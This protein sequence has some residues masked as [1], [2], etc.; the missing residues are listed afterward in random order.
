VATTKEEVMRAHWFSTAATLA[1]VLA[2]ALGAAGEARSAADLPGGIVSLDSNLAVTLVSA[3]RLALTG[4]QFTVDVELTETTG[5][6]GVWTQVDLLNG[7]SATRSKPIHVDSGGTRSV[8]FPVTLNT[9]GSYAFEAQLPESGDPSDDNSGTA[10]VD[11]TQFRVDG[12]NILL[13]SLVGYGG[14]LNHHVFYRPFNPNMPTGAPGLEE[15]IDA[16]E[17]QIV[18]VFFPRLALTQPESLAS[19]YE[20]MEIAQQAGAL[21]NVTWQ[22]NATPNPPLGTI[23]TTMAG[24]ANALAELVTHR[25]IT[26]LRW[27]TVQNEPNSTQMTPET[28][29]RMYRVLDGYL[30]AAG[31]RDQIRFM[32]GDL[33]QDGQRAWFQYMAAHMNDLL[34]AYSVH[35]YWNYWDT[36]KIRQRLEDVRKIDAEELPAAAR[37]PIYVME[38]GVRGIRQPGGPGT[39]MLP[40][41]GLWADG[42]PMAQTTIN[43]FQLGW[44]NVLSA[45]LSYPATATWDLFN[46]KYDNGTQDYSTIGPA[47]DFKLRP[48]YHLLRLFTATTEPG[49]RIVGLDGE[50]GG[51][52]MTA[53]NSTDG[54]LTIVGLDREDAQFDDDS[55]GPGVYSVAGLPSLTTFKLVVWNRDG[56]G[57]LSSDQLVTTDALGIAKLTVPQHAVWALT[58]HPIDD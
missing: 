43:A 15:K 18:R 29:E 52:L 12:G 44:F 25:G 7:D 47:P 39:P 48:S 38:Y 22:S 16:L 34:D 32:G 57:R 58:T 45:R 10:L 6:A 4:R 5:N 20:V 37:K 3:P 35:I 40:Q 54:M 55:R 1:L 24:F 30:R 13:S 8:S 42:T 23:Q 27:V 50:A 33:V 31:V 11:A 28:Y 49:W 19:F 51:K 56:T 26:N 53:Y 9:N 46:A 14:Q 41:P 17:P 36:G 21:I 2:L